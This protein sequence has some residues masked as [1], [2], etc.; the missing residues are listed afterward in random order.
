MVRNLLII[1]VHPRSKGLLDLAPETID[2]IKKEAAVFSESG[3][4]AIASGLEKLIQTVQYSPAARY[5]LE[6]AVIRFAS[7]SDTGSIPELITRL[8]RLEKNGCPG[9]SGCETER[10]SVKTDPKTKKDFFSLDEVEK[11]WG[12]VI[13]DVEKKKMSIAPAL[14]EAEPIETEEGVLVLGFPQEF[15]FHKE[16]IEKPEIKTLIEEAL[17]DRLGSA[18]RIKVVITAPDVDEHAAEEKPDEAESK[19]VPPIVESAMD[20]FKQGRIIRKD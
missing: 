15:N 13:Q 20:I 11:V 12:K 19:E 17:K 1:K 3:L 18:L 4:L 5:A 6:A 14:T 16:S 10:P 7:V 8:E 2:E 9:P